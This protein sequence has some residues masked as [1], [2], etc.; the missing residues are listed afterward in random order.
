MFHWLSLRKVIL[1]TLKTDRYKKPKLY[2]NK[3][4]NLLYG[5]SD[6]LDIFFLDKKIQWVLGNEMLHG[7]LT[8]P[9]VAEYSIN[10]FFFLNYDQL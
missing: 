5:S 9:Y 7:C 2:K 3:C 8:C 6:S 10:M 1:D 4:L